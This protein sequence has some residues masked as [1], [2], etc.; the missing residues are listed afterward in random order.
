LE[1][2]VRREGPKAFLR[3]PFQPQALLDAIAQALA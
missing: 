1:L 2:E 3:K